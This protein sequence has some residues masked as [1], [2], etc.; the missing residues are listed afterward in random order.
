MESVDKVI[1]HIATHNNKNNIRL[2]RLIK[3]YYFRIIQEL[4]IIVR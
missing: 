4:Y 3:K 1:Q 2:A